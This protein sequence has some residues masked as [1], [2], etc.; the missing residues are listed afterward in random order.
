MNEPMNDTSEALTPNG[1]ELPHPT[2][3]RAEGSDA[4]PHISDGQPVA[5]VPCDTVQGADYYVY[6]DY[7]QGAHLVAWMRATAEGVT[8]ESS[9]KRI[10]YEATNEPDTWSRADGSTKQYRIVGR[11]LGALQDVAAIRERERAIFRSVT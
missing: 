11:V 10:A 6:Y 9:G 7:A 8:M 5:A 2:V 3:I 4:E 1:I